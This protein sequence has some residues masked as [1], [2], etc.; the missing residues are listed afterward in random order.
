[1][2]NRRVADLDVKRDLRRRRRYVNQ[3]G[4]GMEGGDGHLGF[5]NTDRATDNNNNT[6]INQMSGGGNE[7]DGGRSDGGLAES[8]CNTESN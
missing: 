3:H 2:T 8:L 4:M 5:A 7:T 1:M 6:D